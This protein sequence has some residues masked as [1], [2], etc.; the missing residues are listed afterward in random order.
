[1]ATSSSQGRCVPS[2]YS[3]SESFSA[4]FSFFFIG[5]ARDAVGSGVLWSWDAV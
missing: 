1:M 2:L 3:F 4:D 5:T